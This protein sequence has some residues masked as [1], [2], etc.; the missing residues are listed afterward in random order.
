LQRAKNWVP[1]SSATLGLLVI[2]SLL[3]AGLARP[4]LGR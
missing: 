2:V 1:A 4:A 3:M